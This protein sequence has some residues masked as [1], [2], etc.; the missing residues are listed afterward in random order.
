MLDRRT[1]LGALAAGAAGLSLPACNN[2]DESGKETSES[3]SGRKDM[4]GGISKSDFGKTPDGQ[5]VELYTLTN[6]KGMTA[7]IMTYGGI[8]VELHAPDK[9]GK[10]ANVNLG[11]DSLDKYVQ[12]NPFFGAITGR[13][14]NRIAK[15]KFTLD[16]KEYTL[17]V[18][19]GPNHLHGGKVG[20]DKRVWRATTR[21]VTGGAALVLTYL[22]KDMEEGYPGN[23]STEV[24]YTLTNDNELRIDYKATTDKKT[25]VNLTNH[26]Y[27]NLHGADSGTTILDH[28]LMIN[29]D[30]YTLGDDTLIPTGEIA[31]VKG[32]PLDF[33]RPTPIG[34]RIDQF[35]KIGGYDHN[36][37]LNGKAGEMKPA[38]R[39][40]DPDSGRVMEIH[41]TEPGVQLYTGIHLNKPA[42]TNYVKYSAFCL[43]TQHFPDSVNKPN[44]PSVVLEPGKTFAST[45]THK[46]SAK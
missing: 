31:S 6:S 27:W 35:P 29:A 1:F 9:N 25:I 40:M 21:D 5:S 14:A 44:F 8:L 32:T 7:K 18:N 19:N 33:T 39:V 4:K 16:G 13:V 23:L 42:G 36:Y 20:F 28:V 45:T 22:S 11:F 37:V 26:A 24:T 46:F 38:A 41:T 3:G 12:H 43:E 34:Q 17:A 2:K 15:G 30:R 10:F